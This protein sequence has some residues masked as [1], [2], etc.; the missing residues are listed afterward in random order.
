MTDALPLSAPLQRLL[1]VLE[2][3]SVPR[4]HLSAN[5]DIAQWTASLA[6]L[7]SLREAHPA[8]FGALG[9]AGLSLR[10]GVLHVGEPMAHGPDRQRLIQCL[11]SL[12]PWRKGP[13]NVG[14]VDIDTE[15]RSDW[16]WQRVRPHLPVL[17]GATVLD[18]GCANGYYA[19]CMAL[20]GARFVLGIEP[21][22][23]NVFQFL[24]LDALCPQSDVR[25]L[26]LSIDDVP[27]D[28]PVFDAV[29]SMGLLYHRRA[30]LAHLEHLHALALPGG[31]VVV[32]TL[33]LT[34]PELTCLS[35]ADRYAGM[36]NVWHIPS[37]PLLSSW[38]SQA[39]FA[40]VRVVDVTRTTILEQRAT[41]WM[42]NTSLA[43]ALDPG[44]DRLTREGHPAPVRAVIIGRKAAC[45]EREL[46][47]KREAP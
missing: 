27:A 8:C 7:S 1:P 41:A 6:T 37:V 33:V 21:Y 11:Q 28:A 32:E 2:A 46:G 13:L 35:P 10:D 38:M 17:R 14:G 25:V 18:V 26:P 45:Q 16:K 9:R 15:W 43:D 30:P 29:F 22:M 40:D 20:E 19:L 12:S 23:R 5:S 34:A 42:T 31:T 39:G 36:R 4:L 44:D 47:A 3:L 24:A